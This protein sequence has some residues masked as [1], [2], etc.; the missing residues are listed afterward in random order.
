MT[1]WRDPLTATIRSTTG[2]DRVPLLDT[3]LIFVIDL[4]GPA[5]ISDFASTVSDPAVPLTIPSST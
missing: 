4:I 3:D 5:P 1:V 2:R